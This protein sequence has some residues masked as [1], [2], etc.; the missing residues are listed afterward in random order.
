[1]YLMYL[2]YL[3]CSACL[4]R[5]FDAFRITFLLLLTPAFY[6]ISICFNI[7]ARTVLRLSGERLL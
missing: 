7:A 3:M 1:M 4:R 2:M 6:F 5:L